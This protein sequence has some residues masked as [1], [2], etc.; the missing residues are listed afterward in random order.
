MPS[1]H[2]P[3][4][5]LASGVTMWPSAVG[6]VIAVDA[7]EQFVS[8]DVEEEARSV[9]L[10]TRLPAP[11]EV[12]VRWPRLAEV[13]QGMWES[14]YLVAGS[15]TRTVECSVGGEGSTAALL[16]TLL[17]ENIEVPA[18]DEFSD[19]HV[20]IRVC[21]DLDSLIEAGRRHELP[22]IVEGEAI[23]IGP[24]GPESERQPG[25]ADLIARR[26]AA[27]PAPDLLEELWSVAAQVPAH[28]AARPARA[29]VAAAGAWLLHELTS[30]ATVIRDYQA[31][32]AADLSVSV[33]P[34]LRRP[35]PE[36]PHPA[37][38]D[39]QGGAT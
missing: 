2:S 13:L 23:A 38:P 34:V 28:R 39:L 11:D 9:L 35:R 26:L 32:V 6:T 31:V 20:V 15:P 12:A 33:H 3:D 22:V 4:L 29:T 37:R 36:D 25:V 7:E 30:G 19:Q 16:R 21:T 24:W 14:G 27:H 18:T 1:P 10:G 8:L 5:R 17:G